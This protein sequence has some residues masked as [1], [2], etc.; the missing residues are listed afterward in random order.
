MRVSTVLFAVVAAAGIGGAAAAAPLA[1]QEVTEKKGFVLPHVL[2]VMASAIAQPMP[3]GL[4]VADQKSYDAETAWLKSVSDRLE[5]MGI[6]NGIVSPRDPA[7]GLATGKR[8]HK[9]YQFTSDWKA[10]Q[11]IVEQEAVQFNTLSN[12]SK[13]RHD[14]AMNAIRNLKA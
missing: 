2:E 3:R 8:Q 10:L 12:A 6:R 4:S 11:P 1:A 9:P 13:A 5:A 14:I 7:T